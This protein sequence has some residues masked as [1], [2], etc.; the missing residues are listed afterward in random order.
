MQIISHVSSM[1]PHYSPIHEVGTIINL[2]CEWEETW[3]DKL[4]CLR[5][6]S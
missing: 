2:M 1:N 5:S 3:R 6:Q 4:T